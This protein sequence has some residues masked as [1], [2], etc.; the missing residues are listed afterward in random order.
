MVGPTI[1]IHFKADHFSCLHLFQV[2]TAFYLGFYGPGNYFPVS[3][4][5][6]TVDF[7]LSYERNIHKMYL[8]ASCSYS[9]PYWV[10][11]LLWDKSKALWG[12]PLSIPCL[13]SYHIPLA[14]AARALPEYSGYAKLIPF[15]WPLPAGHLLQT[16]ALHSIQLPFKCQWSRGLLDHF[17]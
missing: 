16:L 7:S 13:I 1:Q 10:F 12:Q 9:T 15:S 3:L 17:I 5:A 6:P 11:S 8:S 14:Q 4:L 2:T